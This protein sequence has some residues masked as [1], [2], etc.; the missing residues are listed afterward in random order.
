MKM[1]LQ[2]KSES[3]RIFLLLIRQDGKISKQERDLMLKIGK[4]LDF[5]RDF[6][7]TAIDDVLE[8]PH[9]SLEP[10]RFSQ[11]EFA[12]A[13]L[14]DGIALALADGS[15]DDSERAWLTLVA[16]ENGI[17]C[18]WLDEEVELVKKRFPNLPQELELQ[19]YVA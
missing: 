14:K 4:M 16:K 7:E 10:H 6:S 1:T 11:P 17:A 13:F 5:A 3:F 2:D 15:L 19:R 9:I 8:N 12:K 18:E